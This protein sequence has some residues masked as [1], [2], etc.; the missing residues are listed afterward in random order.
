AAAPAWATSTNLVFRYDTRST[1]NSVTFSFNEGQRKASA[2]FRSF[3]VDE[4]NYLEV[5]LSNISLDDVTAPEWILTAVFFNL[6]GDTELTPISAILPFGS[7][8][9]FVDEQPMDEDGNINV[10]GEWAYWRRYNELPPPRPDQGISSTGIDLVGPK[11]LFPPKKDLAK[12]LSPDG[13]QYGLTSLGDLYDDP[14]VGNWPVTGKSPLI[15]HSVVFTLSGLLD[16]FDVN[17]DISDVDFWYG[18]SRTPIPEPLTL[19]GLFLGI[20][21][22]GG[23]IRRRFR[24]A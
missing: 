21:G 10:G 7:S 17:I 4:E 12:P 16:N 11:D 20:A 24:P 19:V 2:E 5:I 8:V 22:V 18:T 14:D 15:Q 3:T 1:G 13:L 9:L 23:Y 6:T